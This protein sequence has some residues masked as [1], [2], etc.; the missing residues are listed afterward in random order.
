MYASTVAAGGGYAFFSVTAADD[1]GA[2]SVAPQGVYARSD[3]AAARAEAEAVYTSLKN[4]LPE[5]GSGLDQVV[6]VEQYVRLKNHA[7]GY[8][9]AALRP[10]LLGTGTANG[11]T[12]QIGTFVPAEAAIQITG[13]AV[14]PDESAG[15][16]KSFPGADGSPTGKFA[17][18]VAAGPYFFTTMFPMDRNLEGLPAGVKVG[19]WSWND[20]EI[21]SETAWAID[22]LKAKLAAQGATLAD[23]VNYSVLLADLGDLYE[24]DLL[25]RA[26]IGDDTRAPSRSLLHLAGSALPRREGAFGHEEGAA[27]L[28]IQFRCAIPGGGAITR[29]G[30]PTEESIP[31]SGYQSA[32]AK[33]DDI[34]WLSSE[35][36]SDAVLGSGSAEIDDIF[37]KLAA[38]CA[39]AGSD[40][41][42][43]LRVRAQLSDAALVP[44]FYRALRKFVPDQ[45]PAV[46]LAVTTLAVPGAH[47]S[48]D[49]VAL[50]V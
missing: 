5:V 40:I 23:I 24:F 3:A 42:Q 13:M 8:F 18:P 4:A 50:A 49:G 37:T 27:R 6:Q 33:V 9:A 44:D 34:V 30:T 45:P 22:Q 1:Q 32:A 25:L 29:V 48:I 2:L 19:G 17:D 7:D 20:S 35:F 38:T 43:L 46:A 36:A 28:E 16:V 21:R 31:Q 12:A 41:S 14:V 39:D 11:A 15:R 47:A 26:A 10:N